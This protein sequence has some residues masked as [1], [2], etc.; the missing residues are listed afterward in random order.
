MNALDLAPYCPFS[1]Q[2][3]QV[4]GGLRISFAPCML[5]ACMAFRVSEEPAIQY[6]ENKYVKCK[7]LLM[8]ASDDDALLINAK[9]I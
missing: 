7:C 6:G 8:P 5:G 9:V 1:K 2:D 4:L 3:M